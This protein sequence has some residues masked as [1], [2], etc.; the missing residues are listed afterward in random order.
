[1]HLLSLSQ[2]QARLGN[3]SRSSI[4]RDVDAGRLPGPRRIGGRLYWLASDIDAM[5]EGLPVARALD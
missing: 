3:R 1:M 5:I 2:V 4:M